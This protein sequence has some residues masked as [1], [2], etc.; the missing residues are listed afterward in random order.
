MNKNYHKNQF[1]EC[2]SEWRIERPKGEIS[3]NIN[4]DNRALSERDNVLEEIDQLVS[5]PTPATCCDMGQ[6]EPSTVTVSRR[7]LEIHGHIDVLLNKA[8]QIREALG[9][10]L[11]SELRLV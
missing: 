3:Q 9:S 7:I 2:Q 5:F 10:Q 4:L 8:I 11:D 1:A 6:T